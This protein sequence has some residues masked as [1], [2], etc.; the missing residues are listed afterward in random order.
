[1]TAGLEPVTSGRAASAH[2]HCLSSPNVQHAVCFTTFLDKYTVI[3]AVRLEP[4]VGVVSLAL[5]AV[6][7]RFPLCA[8]RPGL[9][10]AKVLG[11]LEA[12]FSVAWDPF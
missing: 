1:M 12:C 2:K 11:R 8:H 5:P 4:W 7:S 9:G 10:V 6:S 3:S